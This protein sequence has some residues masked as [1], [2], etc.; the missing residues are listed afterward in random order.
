M[1]RLL[2]HDHSPPAPAPGHDDH[3]YRHAGSASLI[4]D[5]DGTLIREH[6]PLDGASA[7][8]HAFRGRFVIVSNNST[9]TSRQLA[10]RL[11]RMGLPVRPADLVLAG[12]QM[13]AYLRR[14]HA[15]ARVL[16]RASAALRRHAAARGCQL[17]DRDAHVVA[18]ALDKRFDYAALSDLVRELARGARLV[19]SNA[20]LS[21]PG[22]DGLAIPETGALL[23]AVQA[24]SG[25]VPWHVVGK[26]EP[27]M[28]HEG[29]RR[30]G[31]APAATLVIGDNP[32]T[33]ALGARRAGLRHVLVGNDARASAATPAELLARWRT[34]A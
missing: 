12:E 24:C 8:L 19:V 31:S 6:E 18:L 34:A 16:L 29:L 3:P 30:L 17:V 10:Q 14:E 11:Q 1:P 33:D 26:P 4:L 13:V 21:H 28:F 22:P 23:Q 2:A 27:A 7:L 32:D 5:L 15:G 25:I 9:H 20:D